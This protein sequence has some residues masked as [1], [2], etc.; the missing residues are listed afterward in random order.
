MRYPAGI[1]NADPEEVSARLSDT[2]RNVVRKK[3]YRDIIL[4]GYSAGALIVRKAFLYAGGG[5]K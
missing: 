5:T 2:V 4:V 1:S 3:N